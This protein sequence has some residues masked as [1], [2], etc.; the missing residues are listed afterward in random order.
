MSALPFVGI[1]FVAN[2]QFNTGVVVGNLA[3]AYHVSNLAY[4]F[5]IIVNPVGVLEYL[6]YVMVFAETV[7]LPT[8]LIK[9]L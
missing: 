5:G 6:A 1:C 8:I 3:Q 2:V 9:V 4:V 7:L